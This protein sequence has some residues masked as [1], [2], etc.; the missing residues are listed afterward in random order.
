LRAS[1]ENQHKERHT[2]HSAA[3]RTM[4]ELACERRGRL[5]KARLIEQ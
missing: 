2:R 3:M 1:V 5:R 4:I